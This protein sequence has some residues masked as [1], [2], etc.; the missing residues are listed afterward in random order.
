MRFTYQDL[1]PEHD[2]HSFYYVPN[3]SLPTWRSMTHLWR[4]RKVASICSAGEVPLTVLL[5]ITKQ[6]LYAVDHSRACLTLAMSKA[7]MIEKMS[8]PDILK[9]VNDRPAFIRT[10]EE[11]RKELP[12]EIRNKH[13]YWDGKAY[14]AIW[15]QAAKQIDA[16]RE[17]LE[18][19][20]FV[21]GDVQDL[22]SFGEFHLVYA[23][24]I[25]THWSVVKQKKPTTADI[26]PLLTKRGRLLFVTSGA[27]GAFSDLKLQRCV[28][29]SRPDPNCNEMFWRYHAYTPWRGRRRNPSPPPGAGMVPA[30]PTSSTTSITI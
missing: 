2:T 24:N 27:P 21:H 6:A 22:T 3:E 26:R 20:H 12:P 19:L 9:L 28:A 15:L 1:R 10:L 14:R 8:T 23:S 25:F 4:P 17:R 5:P 7:L 30:P 13:D 16:A 29:D 11:L 18:L